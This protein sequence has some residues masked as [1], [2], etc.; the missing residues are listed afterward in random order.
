MGWIPTPGAIYVPPTDWKENLKGRG[1]FGKYN[2]ITFTEDI[3]KREANR[4]SP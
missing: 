2:K 3:M 4:P 1:K